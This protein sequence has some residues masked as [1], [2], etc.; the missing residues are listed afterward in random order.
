MH[1]AYRDKENDDGD[2]DDRRCN[3]VHES[4][5]IHGFGVPDLSDSAE[6]DSCAAVFGFCLSVSAESNKHV[7]V[8]GV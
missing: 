6:S 4:S 7:P 3:E 5:S 2:A 8:L 1:F